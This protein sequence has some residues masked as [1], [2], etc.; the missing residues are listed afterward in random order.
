MCCRPRS[1]EG[2]DRRFGGCLVTKVPSRSPWGVGL[3]LP[4]ESVRGLIQYP[5]CFFIIWPLSGS[6]ETTQQKREGRFRSKEL[7]RKTHSKSKF[8]FIYM[9]PTTLTTFLCPYVGLLFCPD[10]RRVPGWSKTLFQSSSTGVVVRNGDWILGRCLLGPLRVANEETE[11]GSGSSSRRFRD[12]ENV[13]LK[14]PSHVVYTD[15]W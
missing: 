7:L 1:G 13:S 12:M 2:D 11:D 9:S 10:P 8:F 15:Q 5:P 6:F 3:G 4:N 14:T